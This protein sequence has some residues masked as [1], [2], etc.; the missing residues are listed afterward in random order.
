[1]R[2]HGESILGA[3]RCG[4]EARVKP[5]IFADKFLSPRV[6]AENYRALVDRFRQN[7]E[8]PPIIYPPHQTEVIAQAIGNRA[9]IKLQPIGETCLSTRLRLIRHFW[10]QQ[11]TTLK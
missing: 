1:M 7:E 5:K 4:G 2:E 9:G 8:T 11:I 6:L 3:P 10:W